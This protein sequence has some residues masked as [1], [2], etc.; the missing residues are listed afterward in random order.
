MLF[1]QRHCIDKE[2]DVS[3][4]SDFRPKSH[5]AKC[6]VEEKFENSRWECRYDVDR[7]NENDQGNLTSQIL[8]V[9]V[10]LHW[11][12]EIERRVESRV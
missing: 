3:V 4:V 7:G 5:L 12:G 1:V 11:I 10:E 9:C 2:E 8:L 6:Q